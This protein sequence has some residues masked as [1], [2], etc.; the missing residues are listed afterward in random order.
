MAKAKYRPPMWS[1]KVHGE[2]HGMWESG[3]SGVGG[4]AEA[5]PLEQ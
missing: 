5:T 3:A 1:S 2:P 4:A